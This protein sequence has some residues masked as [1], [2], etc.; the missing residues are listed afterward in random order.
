[1]FYSLRRQLRW[2]VGEFA[3]MDQVLP[4][5]HK[6]NDQR[7]WRLWNSLT[8]SV[9]SFGP[10]CYSFYWEWWLSI[11]KNWG[12]EQLATQEVVTLIFLWFFS[13]SVFSL[14]PC[15]HFM[16]FLKRQLLALKSTW[17]CFVS[18]TSTLVLNYTLWNFLAVAVVQ[19]PQEE[20]WHFGLHAREQ[21][22]SI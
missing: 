4:S 21:T 2:K 1:M 9:V 22:G 18:C 15:F 8:T 13:I 7:V 12:W 11:A 20:W 3:K 5:K 16:P 14:L 17:S 19:L 6:P 10:G